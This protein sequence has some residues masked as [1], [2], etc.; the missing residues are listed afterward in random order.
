M[1]EHVPEAFSHEAQL[2]LACRSA[3]A[4]WRA[5]VCVV[6]CIYVCVQVLVVLCSCK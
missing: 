3:V 6:A 1:S 4:A 2:D 5:R